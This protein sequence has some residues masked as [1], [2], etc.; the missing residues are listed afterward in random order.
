M[1]MVVMCGCIMGIFFTPHYTTIIS[2]QTHAL[3]QHQ[4]NIGFKSSVCWD[5]LTLFLSHLN[6]YP[7]Q[8][9][10]NTPSHPTLPHHLILIA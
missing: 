7:H 4:P 5:D 9:D 1:S 6:P 3:N 10:L 2:Q 8:P